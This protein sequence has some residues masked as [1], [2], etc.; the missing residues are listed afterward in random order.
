[1]KKYAE[2]IRSLDMTPESASAEYSQPIRIEPSA[3]C[4]W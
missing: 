1:V 3:Y 4:S 2:G